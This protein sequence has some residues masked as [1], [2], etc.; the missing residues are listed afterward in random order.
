[1]DAQKQDDQLEPMY[2]SSVQIQD[3][4]LKTSQVQWTI[5]TGGERESGKSVLVARHDDDDDINWYTNAI[6]GN[7]WTGN[8]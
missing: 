6:T 8:D 1:M 3:I 5:E 7:R 4:E 2:N